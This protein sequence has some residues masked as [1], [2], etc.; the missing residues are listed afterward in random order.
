M[1]GAASHPE[2]EEESRL[3]L[4]RFRTSFRQPEVEQEF[5]TWGL[6]RARR[7]ALLNF[8][9]PTL[10]YIIFSALVFSVK[11]K[12]AAPWLGAVGL[13]FVSLVLAR[14][15]LRGSSVF[16]AEFCSSVSIALTGLTGI[17]LGA[18][19][20]HLHGVV[21]TGAVWACFFHLYL[22]PSYARVSRPAMAVASY[23]LLEAVFIGR[24]LLA[25]QVETSNAVLEWFFLFTAYGT[26]LAG[27]I[28]LAV[29]SRTSYRQRLIIESQQRVVDRERAR[30][31]ELLRQELSHQV[32][33]R[34]RDLGELITKSV[35]S[36]GAR[37]LSPGEQ[38]DTRY[39]VIQALGRG[40]MGAVYEVE[41]L[42][43][44]LHLA[45]KVVS[46][47]I[48]GEGA[49][50][51][52]REAEIGARLRHPNL[53]SIVDVGLATGVPFLVM[54][55][56][57]G[58][59]LEAKRQ[60]FG[61]VAW[62]LPILRQIALGLGTLHQADV[63]HRDLKPANVLLAEDGA[64][65]IAKIS[66]FGISRIGTSAD[67]AEIDPSAATIDPT[68]SQQPGLRTRTGALLGTPLY[69]APEASRGGR[70]VE[71]P[72]DVF[73]FGIMAYEMLTARAPFAAPAV[74]FATSGQP[75]PAVPTIENARVPA[76]LGALVLE[77]LRPDPAQRPTIT[78][79]LSTLENT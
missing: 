39:H 10:F 25:G 54:E 2:S 55:L 17:A 35:D 70:A 9:V 24:D 44:R 38:F 71:T 6:V 46:G 66:D 15:A 74:F 73:A 58:A 68:S 47:P 27:A 13:V 18:L 64:S 30:N 20:L 49:A 1:S 76:A 29:S 60:R 28:T 19:H 69:M 53:V 22:S 34:S 37:Q 78:K 52:A 36:R 43:D 31:E 7:M 56:V 75:L 40:G 11:Q 21:V 16:W 23:I 3:K 57:R 8:Y 77:C 72:A 67:N 33:Q 32:A 61:D 42:T 48:S 62:A 59:S 4:S 26:A 50:R 63:V 41:R 79:I 65:V 5:R 14:L 45:L 51:F 12:G